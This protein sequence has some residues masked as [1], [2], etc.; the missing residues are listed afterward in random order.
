VAGGDDVRL[1]ALGLLILGGIVVLGGWV[2]LCAGNGQPW[3]VDALLTATTLVLLLLLH[4]LA[5]TLEE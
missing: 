3:T 1:A 2:W 4:R 5:A